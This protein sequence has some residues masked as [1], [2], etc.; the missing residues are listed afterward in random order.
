MGYVKG[1]HG[2][3]GE[4]FVGLF[5]ERADWLDA[6]VELGLVLPRQK[7]AKTYAI[8]AIRPHKEGLIAAL[9]GIITRNDSEALR[10]AHVYIDETALES[11]P[12]EPIFL[13][14]IEGFRLIDANDGEIGTITGFSTNTSQD[15]LRVTTSG[16]DAL[17]PFVEAFLLN[18]D[19]DKREVKMDL[20]PGLLDLGAKS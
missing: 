18:I 12:G 15:L 8:E 17:V 19:F 11:E 3:R 14:Q 5:A 6:V 20:P 2:I 16:G 7:E 1:A 10:G 13:R 4:V 9:G